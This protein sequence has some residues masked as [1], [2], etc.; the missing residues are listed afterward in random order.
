MYVFTVS[1]YRL[2]AIF[3]RY[4]AL[5]AI[6][7]LINFTDIAFSMKAKEK[8]M[9]EEVITELLT[10][11]KLELLHANTKTQFFTLFHSQLKKVIGYQDAVIYSIDQNNNSAF[12]FFDD[13]LIQKGTFTPIIKSEKSSFENLLSSGN[14]KSY[15]IQ[16]DLKDLAVYMED[17]VI[18]EVK[19]GI[20]INLFDVEKIIGQWVICFSDINASAPNLYVLEAIAPV[21][22]AKLNTFLVQ[23]RILLLEE[24]NEIIQSLSVDFAAIR[25]KKDLLK[26]IHLK[27]KKLFEF[28]DH[29]VA[30]IN[31]D[32]LT[33]SSFL[34]DPRAWA[35]EHPL[36]QQTVEAKYPINDGI[37]NKVVLSKEP[38]IFD[39]R[40][41]FSRGKM[42]QY[43]IPLYESGITTVILIGL[44][45]WD[46]VIGLWCVCQTSEQQITPNKLRLIKKISNQLAI[47]IENIRANEAI[48]AREKERN[49]LLKLSEDLATIR[50]KNDLFKAINKNL[51]QLFYFED[52]VIMALNEDE[53]YYAF[54]F[55]L[56]HQSSGYTFYQK[57][58]LKKFSYNDCCFQKA[59]EAD[60]VTVLDMEELYNDETAPEYLKFEYENGVREK[61]AI[62][63][64]DDKRN[65]GVFYVN[66]KIAGIYSDHELELI[67]GVSYQLS[68]AVSNILANE[69]IAARE[70]E[71]EVLLSITN[72]ISLVRDHDKLMELIGEK[73]KPQI[74]F[75]HIAIG[76]INDDNETYSTF[77]VDRSSKSRHH[78]SWKEATTTKYPINDGVMNHVFASTTPV[79]FD[80]EEEI[81]HKKV[82]IYFTMLYESGTKQFIGVRLSKE[83]QVF[84]MWAL[85]FDKKDILNKNKLS[86]ITGLANQL[87]ITI[88]NILA[89][90]EIEKRE[91]EKTILLSLSKEI[92][93]LTNRDDFSRMV[94]KR[95][96]QIFSIDQF[97]IAKI[98][99]G[100]DTYCSFVEEFTEETRKV[101]GFNEVMSSN[102][103][104]DDEIFSAILNTE[105]S[106]M[107]DFEEMTKKG[108][109]PGHAHFWLAAGIKYSLSVPLRVGNTNIGAISF[110]VTNKDIINTKSILLK[111]VCAQIG[112]AMSNILASEE[113]KDREIEREILLSISNDIAAVRL[114]GRL[115]EV[116]GQ[117]LKPQL[118]FTHI[119]IGIINDDRKTFRAFLL[120]PGSK[121]QNHSFYK[122]A[123]TRKFPI[124]DGV[125]NKV[126]DTA[127]PVIFDLDELIKNK[128]IPK[129]FIMNYE[130]GI[131]Q[132]IIIRLS[133]G[134]SVFGFWMIH[135]D[136]KDVINKIKLSLIVGLANQLSI[137]VSNIL[138]NEEIGE[139]EVEKEILLTLSNE[140][141]SLKSKNDLFR[142][143]ND[144]IKKIFSIDQFGIAKVNEDGLT[145]SAFMMDLGDEVS[146]QFNFDEVVSLKYSVDDKAFS[147]IM[148]TEDTIIL[149]VD[150]L[151]SDPES[152]VYVKF[153]QAVGFRYL[154]CLGLRVGGTPVGCLFFNVDLEKAAEVKTNLLK[155]VGSQLAVAI[156]N[157][158][159]NEEIEKREL[160]RELLLSLST[161]IAAVRN[162][163]ELL[164]I[165]NNRL[166]NILDF[167]H[168][169]IAIVNDD[170]STFSAYI[171]DPAS[172]SKNHPE[173]E[174]A[175]T[176][177]FPLKE[178]IIDQASSSSIPLIFDFDELQK[179]ADLPLYFRINYE[180]GIKDAIITRFS[181]GDA[182][183]GFW[184]I[185]FNTKKFFEN[186]VLSLIAGLSNQLS[187]AMSNII[188]NDE[189]KGR[190]EEKSM[191]LEFSNA[192][193]SVRD[194][195][196]FAKILKDQ[197]KKLFSIDDYVINILSD[198]EQNIIELLY[199][200]E[201]EIFHNDEFSALLDRPINVNDGVIDKILASEE[202]L[203]FKIKEWS[204]WEK[205]PVYINACTAIGL[206]NLTAI[207]IRMGNKNV[208]FLSFKTDELGLRSSSLQFLKSICSQI[209]IAVSNILA[210][211]K[212]IMQLKVINDYKQQL[213]EEKIYLKEEIETTHNYSEIIGNGFEMQKIFHLVSMVANSDSTVLILGETGT[214]KELIA[215]AIH[216]NSPRQSRLMVKVNCATLPANLIESELFGH[217]RGSFTGATE[218]RIGKFE[219]A[220]KGTLFLDEIGEMPL[221]LQVKLLRALQEKEIERIGG[222]ETI[223][224][225]VR[226]IAATNRDLEKEMSEGRFRSDL[227]YRLNIFPISLPPLRSRPEDIP[228]LAFHFIQR[229]SKKSGRQI[230]KLSNNAMQELLFYNWPGN[231]RELEHLIERSILLSSGDTIKRIQL[232]SSKPK[233]TE[234]SAAELFSLNT[235]DEN[236]RTHIINMLK[237]CGGRIAGDGG[238]AERLGVPTSTLHSK[239]KRLNIKRG[240]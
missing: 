41:Q 28:S 76:L 205:P 67:Q 166:K 127:E 31:D 71:R 39:L 50:D 37:F 239:M 99:E 45:V 47:A 68:I 56:A 190:E 195:F 24:E 78:K 221:E 38:Q 176:S 7:Q 185:F 231:I 117:K 169:S 4:I 23:E 194:K 128:D 145:H 177:R 129:Y 61:V 2:T 149:D 153:W 142:V 155:A 102:Y 154:L 63:L 40:Q 84:G 182:V 90:E 36:Y 172:K 233:D 110:N 103:S 32:E 150:Q 220:H 189:I 236:E 22:A 74:G 53:T 42:P 215:R 80:L 91:A 208:A 5:F 144:S 111:G 120:D 217:E 43:F 112:V 118:G 207:R 206:E 17:T 240:Q 225:D 30:V 193:A 151:A 219:L 73:L 223:K 165:I 146:N 51:K 94:N 167:S 115:M 234:K 188:A 180:S 196:I 211:E 210:N 70:S 137:A 192:I 156:S 16:Q 58:A 122:H 183:F 69:E 121:S 60:G 8:K 148:A 6:T 130:S 46:R 197:L 12:V 143:V 186:D 232:P 19:K 174:L 168:T 27:I 98:N 157:I 226:I 204:T 173:Y 199:D 133:K 147:S 222:K 105:D 109:I 228:S 83:E 181:K 86:L 218:R 184:I 171:I 237:Y 214:G 95:L 101:P 161:D 48:A 64:S 191:L 62:K 238:A 29:F 49:H 119:M 203:T 224:V 26:I 170:K 104:V 88:S 21:I 92:A 235:I 25:E 163:D 11:V 212:V 138:A 113:I 227:Y 54:L 229:F 57:N 108:G 34:Q 81:K 97:V 175:T 213:E 116:I 158:L 15:K 9:P 125:M 52:I 72:D 44:H 179:E 13:K 87:S 202:P 187:I 18:S 124:N 160:E 152:P 33:L 135:F 66:S 123:I 141:A 35:E 140:I 85:M 65:I 96:K 162:H 159:G 59:I 230:N 10:A 79:I 200:A 75:T 201:N 132:V 89:N 107:F 209:A 93:T 3:R 100:G 55:S 198:D 1:V 216:N 20:I 126:F 106:V 134:E 136:K 164:S 82:P 77:L 139:R 178:S 14:T 131:K 114:P